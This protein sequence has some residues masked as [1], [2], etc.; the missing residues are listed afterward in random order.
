MNIFLFVFILLETEF[1][2][3]S[4]ETFKKVF[5]FFRKF[6]RINLKGR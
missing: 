2:W 3:T 4:K 6:Q 5:A 1:D